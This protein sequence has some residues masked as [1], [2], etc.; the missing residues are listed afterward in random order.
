MIIQPFLEA[1]NCSGKNDG[2]G[3]KSSEF[4]SQFSYHSLIKSHNLLISKF[5]HLQNEGV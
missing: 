2:S 4:E 5:P 1:M 3:V